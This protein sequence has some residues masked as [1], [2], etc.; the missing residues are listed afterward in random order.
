[1]NMRY[2]VPGIRRYVCGFAGYSGDYFWAVPDVVVR[3]DLNIDM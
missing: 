3:S 1:M 2:K